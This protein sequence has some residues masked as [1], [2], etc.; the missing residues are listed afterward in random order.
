MSV[1][2]EPL[3][4]TF[5]ADPAHSSFRFTIKHMAVNTFT[6]SFDDVAATLVADAE[7]VRLQGSARAESISIKAP[8]EFREHVVYGADFLDAGQH[9]EI[10]LGSDEIRLA[11]DGTVTA[12]G[13]LT[14]KGIT[15]P[16]VATGTYQA[17]VEDPYGSMRTA[18]EVHATVDRRD[19][20]MGWQAPLPRGGDVLGYEVE[21]VAN[22]ELIQAS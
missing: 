8:K 7:G 3:A 21:L 1:V 15:R 13:W 11:E 22:V 14:I 16:I 6:A 19:W 4:G 20:D 17:P 12:T 9:P 5:V 10:T 18:L 2:T